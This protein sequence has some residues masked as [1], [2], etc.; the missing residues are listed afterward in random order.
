MQPTLQQATNEYLN[1][2]RARGRAKNT[3]DAQEQSLRAFAKA[4][5][6]NLR[7]RAITAKHLD[8]VFT[9]HAD[10]SPGTR[11]N[12]LGHYK[13]FFKWCRARGYMHRDSD[14]AFGWDNVKV[15]N[16]DRFRV[17][18]NEWNNLLD[19]AETPIQRIVLATGLFL[20]LRG[21]EQ[22]FIR[23]EHVH[24]DDAEIEVF[25]VKTQTWDTMPISSEL[26]YYL[27]QHLTWLAKNGVTKPDHFL[28]PSMTSPL[29]R[30][31][32]RFI[33]GTG[34]INPQQ[35]FYRP[36]DVVKAVLANAG[37]STYGEGEHTL[38]RSGARAYFDQLVDDGYD[39]ALRRVMSMLGH[40]KSETTERY[41][42]LDLEKRARNR[43][44][45]R[46]AMFPTLARQD[47]QVVPIRRGL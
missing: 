15:P 40:K 38:R 14:P 7:V 30:N 26:D 4:T 25:R 20:F 42:G 11:N 1:H 21:S 8:Q 28:I 32:G 5:S 12:R 23:L 41:L 19:S 46:Q 34:R 9:K 18:I 35:P 45:K 3:I 37:Y 13:Q 22:Q 6:A 24:L 29:E 44:I 33:A 36:Y 27:R 17:P 31:N 10:W 2:M 39:G 47:A 16:R 43:A